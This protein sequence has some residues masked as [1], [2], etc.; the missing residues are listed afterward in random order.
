MK[1]PIGYFKRGGKTIPIFK[2]EYK[3]YDSSSA[4][5][6]SNNPG[7]DYN[8]SN[9]DNN[10]KRAISD[11]TSGFGYGGSDIVNRYLNGLKELSPDVKK[12]VD[13]KI[14]YLDSAIKNKLSENIQVFRGIDVHPRELSEGL[15]INN[16]GFTS[17]S[18]SRYQASK[19]GTTIKVNVKKG[20]PALF[21]GSNTSSTQNEHELLFGRGHAI[22]ITKI[23]KLF[24]K[25]GDFMN[26][27]IEG[28][29]L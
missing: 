7:V 3:S 13:E 18:I 22:K 20:T 6:V 8:E 15:V 24:D 21:I 17:T 9:L 10:E 4:D 14:K 1:E 27:E 5:F 19:F 28:E 25:D 29:L 16:Y 26:Y 12:I 2:K 23:E 11:Y